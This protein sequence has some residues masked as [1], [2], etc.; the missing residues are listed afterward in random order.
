MGAGIRLRRA[1]S[2]I[3]ASPDGRPDAGLLGGLEP[4][5]LK[6]MVPLAPSTPGKDSRAADL[7]DGIT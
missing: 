5:P 2:T 4:F 1:R 3:Q 7:P 6:S